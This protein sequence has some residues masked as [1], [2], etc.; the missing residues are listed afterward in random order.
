MISL[1][2]EEVT[3]IKVTEEEF[4]V[5]IERD[6]LVGLY[7]KVIKGREYGLDTKVPT[8]L[9]R[10]SKPFRGRI[11]GLKVEVARLDEERANFMTSRRTT[12]VVSFD[13]AKR[14]KDVVKG[15]L[16]ANVAEAPEVDEHV[17]VVVEG[18]VTK[19]TLV[20][21]VVAKAKN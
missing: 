2:R 15:V 11:V 8:K 12:Y 19:E 3:H 13:R 14:Q 10:V 5:K 16:G 20:E 18:V 4:K 1:L 9:R 7:T 21:E 6:N 17:E